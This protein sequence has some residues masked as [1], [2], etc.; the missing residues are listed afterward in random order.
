MLVRPLAA[1]ANAFPAS[2]HLGL[3]PTEGG[4]IVDVLKR[5][6]PARTKRSLLS[7][8][9]HQFFYAHMAVLVAIEL[10]RVSL[11]V[12]R[13]RWSTRAEH[14]SVVLEWE[15]ILIADAAAHEALSP[16]DE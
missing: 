9:S 11:E 14:G 15:K 6:G 16:S 13:P 2:L 4:L 1:A 3:R 5:K 7:F 12:F 8:N 10:A